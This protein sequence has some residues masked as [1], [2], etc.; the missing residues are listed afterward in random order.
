MRLKRSDSQPIRWPT[1][2]KAYQSDGQPI[3]RSTKEKAERSRGSITKSTIHIHYQTDG[4]QSGNHPGYGRRN[5]E[6]ISLSPRSTSHIQKPG[7]Q[8]E[9]RQPPREQG[10]KPREDFAKSTIHI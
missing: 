2:Q 9:T 1:N 5:P 7:G 10:E 8:S 3:G 6:G 4:V